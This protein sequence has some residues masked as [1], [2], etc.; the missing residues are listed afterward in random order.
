MSD[1]IESTEPEEGSTRKL[2]A[3]MFTDIKD[4]SKKMGENET[5]AFELLK[6]HD[7]LMRVVA[8]RFG[9]KVIKSIGDSFMVDFS[10]AVNAVKSAV[11]AQKK[12]WAYNQGKT[13][14]EKIEIRVG[15]HLGDVIIRGED[16]YGDGVNIASR[17]EA[18][19]EPTRIC[20]SQ[21]VYNQVKNKLAIE[22]FRMGPMELKNI[23]EPVE[24]YEILIDSITELS[25]PSA[26]AMQALARKKVESAPA[27]EDEEAREATHIEEA[28]KRATE[29]HYRTEEQKKRMIEEVYT[30]A[31]KYFAEGRFEDAEKELN[32]VYKI[33]PNF[34]AAAEK[35]KEEEEY[36]R[37]AQVNLTN[38]R[39]FIA[40]GDLQA[41]E[42][43]LNEVFRFFPLHSGAQQLLLQIEEER[44][45]I[46]EEERTR[47][48]ATER[49]KEL[50]EEEKKIEELL[51]Q[52]R[53]LLEQ[54]HFHDAALTLRE[55]FALNPNHTAARRLEVSIKE[56]E[57]A[58]VELERVRSEKEAEAKRAEQL[59][60]LQRKLEE[61][62]LVKLQPGEKKRKINYK[63]IGTIVTVFALAAGFYEVAPII[64]K[65]L[66]PKSTSLV[67]VAIPGSDQTLDELQE[68][69]PVL[70][71]GDFAR[72]NHVTVVFT[73][74]SGSSDSRPSSLAAYG[75]VFKVR[76]VVGTM[77]E[78]TDDKISITVKLWD[79]ESQ[80]SLLTSKVEVSDIA[81][82]PKIRMAIVKKILAV[83]QIDSPVEP[84]A[85]AT[86][87]PET[88]D[89]YLKA[90]QSMQRRDK[91][92]L[93]HAQQ[94]LQQV[95][96]DDSSFSQAYA[97]L[98]EVTLRKH[99]L[100]MIDE[101]DPSEFIQHALQADPN[102]SLAYQAL[103]EYYRL[104][105]R[106]DKAGPALQK[107]LELQPANPECYRELALLSLI[108]GDYEGA[109]KHA[110]TAFALDPKNP[111][112]HVV[113]GLV[114]NMRHEF[115]PATT[116][117]REAIA[118]GADDSLLTVQYLMNAWLG[119]GQNES[120]VQ[121]CKELL[122][123]YPDD[124]KI[125]YWIGR[126]Y[127]TIPKMDDAN[128]Y[129]NQG[130]TITRKVLEKNPN[131]ANASSF[132]GLFCT[133]LGKWTDADQYMKRA[134]DLSP[135]SVEL[136]YRQAG[137]YS[138]QKKFKNAATAL[139]AAIAKR[140]EFS[141]IL[142]PDLALFST[143]PEFLPIIT[144][145]IEAPN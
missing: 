40:Q 5:A 145:P 15:I 19:A 117:Y 50:S 39:N 129:L 55:L 137:V 122:R 16:I 79:S 142:N 11:E 62:K 138:I 7:A 22:V 42:K 64:L 85:Q 93:D 61:Q 8:A 101:K 48:T 87:S 69:L 1:L 98:A 75:S 38:A 88:Y 65:F 56:A 27:L 103:G 21:D 10:S 105:Q 36:E 144:R 131:D 90:M 132:A 128:Q 29:A 57:R 97:L 52:A 13:E 143:E 89:S 17:L 70:L 51:V 130:L 99:K 141:G 33:D 118:L 2:A 139:K 111:D 95:V 120:A 45:K 104:A 73:G 125:Y 59:A 107:S 4:F 72:C 116:E 53:K 80:S 20:I 3:I 60:T 134:L 114:H 126:T 109:L 81:S 25:K 26:G 113:A 68:T 14:F 37:K 106:F 82:L 47:R 58:K 43:E 63:L 67:V 9:G 32:E 108:G 119:Q 83:L 66:F 77:V 31:E 49:P 34:Q 110:T 71:T 41:A 92:S 121:F 76:H 140:Y 54:E 115:A 12:F 84:I 24:V 102:N 100:D 18:I 86:T 94:L 46:E 112:S 96:A 74:V 124:Y 44:Y 135:N 133:R 123:Q 136:L 91:S 30:R 78:R 35:K 23:S 127:Q 28:K 6:M